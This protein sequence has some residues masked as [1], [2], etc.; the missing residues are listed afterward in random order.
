MAH[1]GD[2]FDLD[3]FAV[4]LTIVLSQDHTVCSGAGE[5]QRRKQKWCF[6]RSCDVEG[7][8]LK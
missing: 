6:C 1:L 3:W 7:D 2:G 8:H 5:G 4:V